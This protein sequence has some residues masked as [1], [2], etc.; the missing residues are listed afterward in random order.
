MNKQTYLF[1]DAH[2]TGF[3]AM[4]VKGESI[5]KTKPICEENK[6]R[7]IFKKVA[8]PVTSGDIVKKCEA[9][10]VFAD[11]KTKETLRLHKVPEKC[12]EKV[13]VDLFGPMSSSKHIAVVQDL[14][15]RFPH[16]KLVSSTI[17]DK[18][19]PA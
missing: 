16:A 11:K 15:S 1:T 3:G 6:L 4:L 14:A 7:N 12:M 13:A 9:C 2:A 17:G 5:E 18:V 8:A 10:N 19:I